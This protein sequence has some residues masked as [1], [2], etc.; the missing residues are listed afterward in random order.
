M[1]LATPF[2]LPN[3]AMFNT[4]MG[5]DSGAETYGSAVD[6]PG[7]EAGPPNGIGVLANIVLKMTSDDRYTFLPSH[8]GCSI[9]TFKGATFLI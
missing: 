1:L 7:H 4:G 8:V 5:P 3:V 2:H 9:H 6:K